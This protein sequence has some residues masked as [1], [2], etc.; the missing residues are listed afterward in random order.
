[1]KFSVRFAVGRI[2]HEQYCAIAK[3]STFKIDPED[4]QTKHISMVV[5]LNI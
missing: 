5:N 2:Q 1:M 4:M 3:R